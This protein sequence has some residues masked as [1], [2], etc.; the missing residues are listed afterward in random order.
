MISLIMKRSVQR[1]GAVFSLGRCLFWWLYVLSGLCEAFCF[2]MLHE[3]V[4]ISGLVP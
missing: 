2:Q 1:I 4:F 3:Q